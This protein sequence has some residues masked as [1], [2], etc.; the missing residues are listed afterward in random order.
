MN[1]KRK[2]NL[3]EHPLVWDF[4]TDEIKSEFNGDLNEDVSVEAKDS[5]YF[6]D[7]ER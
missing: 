6:I 1:Q 7:D 5:F 4:V 2:L 3:N